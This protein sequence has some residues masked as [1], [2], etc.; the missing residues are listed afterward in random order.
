MKTPN[1][2]MIVEDWRAK[3]NSPETETCF[4]IRQLINTVDYQVGQWLKIHE[5]QEAINS[6]IDVTIK[7]R[8]Y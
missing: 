8:S 7:P 6:G 4:V 3:T 2:K 5:V 1:V